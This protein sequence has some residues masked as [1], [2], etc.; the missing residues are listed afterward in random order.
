MSIGI[1]GFIE[2]LITK[3]NEKVYSVLVIAKKK[4]GEM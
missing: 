3:I 1:R 2:F 4:Y